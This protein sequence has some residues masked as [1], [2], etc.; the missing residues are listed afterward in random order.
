MTQRRG[1]GLSGVKQS[2]RPQLLSE[3]HSLQ[4][5]QGEGEGRQFPTPIGPH[6]ARRLQSSWV[7]FPRQKAPAHSSCCGTRKPWPE[8]G[9]VSRIGQKRQNACHHLSHGCTL[10]N[11]HRVTVKLNESTRKVLLRARGDCL[12]A[13]FFDC[14]PEQS[15]SIASPCPTEG[16]HTHV[17]THTHTNTYRAPERTCD[18]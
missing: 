18:M 17:C 6:P 3:G 15:A 12:H 5:C 9:E 11:L 1:S 8:P 13:D 2:H 10:V 16:T 7:C 4:C 14:F